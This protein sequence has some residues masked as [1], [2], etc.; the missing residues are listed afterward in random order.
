MEA[1]CKG[2]IYLHAD[3]LAISDGEGEEI[4]KVQKSTVNCYK[5]VKILQL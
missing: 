3:I 4:W 2:L 1:D 5:T